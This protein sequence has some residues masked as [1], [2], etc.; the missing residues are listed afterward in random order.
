MLIKQPWLKT[1][2]NLT[3]ENL[4][5]KNVLFKFHIFLFNFFSVKVIAITEKKLNKKI[6]HDVELEKQKKN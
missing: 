2:K 3:S 1:V 4:T 6:N 5:F